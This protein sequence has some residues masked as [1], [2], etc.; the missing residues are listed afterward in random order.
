MQ[1]TVE[2]QEQANSLCSLQQLQ[3]FEINQAIC[4]VGKYLIIDLL[5]ARNC[6]LILLKRGQMNFNLVVIAIAL[7]SLLGLLTI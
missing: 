6:Q 3:H 5:L 1:V 7:R 2:K 4:A